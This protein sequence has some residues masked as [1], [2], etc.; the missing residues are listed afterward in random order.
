M[1]KAV[2]SRLYQKMG[3]ELP[4]A[5]VEQPDA[6]IPSLPT[7]RPARL[8]GMTSDDSRDEA[9]AATPSLRTARVLRVT[10]ETCEVW[11][12]GAVAVVAFAPTVPAPRTERVSPGHL[13]AIATPADGR[14]VVVWRWFDAVVLGE[15]ADGSVRLWEA[16]HGEVLARRRPGCRH[17]EPGV[18]A[19]ASAGLP[20]ADWWVASPV[21]AGDV[22]PPVDLEEVAAFYASNDLWEA[23]LG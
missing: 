2:G 9:S 3:T 1:N 5:S 22:V 11:R 10:D 8:A 14:D 19:Y 12:D 15:E 18:R 6:R 7:D 13:V 16:A 21:G 4:R 17:L 23:A 20:G